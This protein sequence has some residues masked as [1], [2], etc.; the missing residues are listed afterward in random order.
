MGEAKDTNKP[1]ATPNLTNFPCF[2]VRF[3]LSLRPNV[4]K[5]ELC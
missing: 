1:N 2:Y 3:V 5:K 4:L